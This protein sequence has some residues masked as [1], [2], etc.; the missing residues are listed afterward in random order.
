MHHGLAQARVEA[1]TNTLRAAQAAYPERF[2][3]GPPTAPQPPTA[4]WINPPKT[5]VDAGAGAPHEDSP[6]KAGG[7]PEGHPWELEAGADREDD[8]ARGGRYP[9]LGPAIRGRRRLSLDLPDLVRKSSD[10]DPRIS[11]STRTVA[12]FTQQ[13]SHSH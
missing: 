3:H 9:S 12:K 7:E 1:R 5:T 4:V 11:T 2:V 10:V 13:L 6:H 8:V